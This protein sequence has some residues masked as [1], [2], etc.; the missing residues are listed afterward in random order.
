MGGAQKNDH[1]LVFFENA[2]NVK[3]SSA[4][5][6]G[7]EKSDLNRLI[8]GSKRCQFPCFPQP[9]TRK[10]QFRPGREGV[11][12]SLCDVTE[13]EIPLSGPFRTLGFPCS[14]GLAEKGWRQLSAKHGNQWKSVKLV[15][16]D[17]KTTKMTLFD[18]FD[19]LGVH[20]LCASRESVPG[21]LM[22]YF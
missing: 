8:S 1:F 5:F 9:E 7:F 22:F 12:P 6:L 4:G 2:R 3:T 16:C 14:P 15:F 18:S 21:F 20:K 17:R 19:S 10:L 11:R 13:S